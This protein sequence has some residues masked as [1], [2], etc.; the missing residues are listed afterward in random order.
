MARR[1]PGH[2]NQLNILQNILVYTSIPVTPPLNRICCIARRDPWHTNQ[3]TQAWIL[4]RKSPTVQTHNT[5]IC[6]LTAHYNLQTQTIQSFRANSNY[7]NRANS[8]YTTI[9]KLTLY[10]LQ[11]QTKQ[12]LQ[13]HSIKPVQTCS[14]QSVQ[15]LKFHIMPDS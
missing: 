9:C 11:T 3:C 8:H 1:N 6:K 7:T 2:T 4:Q 14:T 10:N 13:S 5:T 15:N 12:S